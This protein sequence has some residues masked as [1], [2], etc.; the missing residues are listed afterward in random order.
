MQHS[1]FGLFNSDAA[2]FYCLFVCCKV[3]V[4]NFPF[5]GKK[6][7]TVL[8]SKNLFHFCWTVGLLKIYG[9]LKVPLLPIPNE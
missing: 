8:M 6:D 9:F 4:Q 3:V 7:D 2:M 5:Y 1:D